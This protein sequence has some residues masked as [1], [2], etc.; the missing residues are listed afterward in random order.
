MSPFIHLLNGAANLLLRTVGLRAPTEMERVHRPEEI[1]MLLTQ[2]Y[3]HG[4]LSE[5]PVEMIR[6]V[7]GL[8]ETIAAEVMTPRTDVIALDVTT[9]VQEA[10]TFILEEGHSRY[11]VF[12]ETIDHIVGIVLAREVWRAQVQGAT[13]LAQVMRPPLFVPDTKPVEGLLRDMRRERAH[14]AVVIDEFGGTAGIITI[15]DMLEEI[16]G[17]ISDELDDAAPGLVHGPAGEVLLTGGMAIADLNDLLGLHL[18]NEDYTTVGG[19]VLGRL[20][21]VARVGDEVRVRGGTMR[22]LEMD[23]RR[24]MR[25]ALFLRKPPPTTE[26]GEGEEE[27][28]DEEELE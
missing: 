6:G 13:E 2:S 4:L 20:G 18:P 24:V 17:E 27:E 8:S 14:M 12:E 9:T 3:E 22:V 19:F 11:P 23:G 15:E 28:V 7:F 1:E 10:A 16:V 5:E 25:L 26:E 21:R